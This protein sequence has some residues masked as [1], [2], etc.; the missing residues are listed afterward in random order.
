[1]MVKDETLLITLLF[2]D[3][4]FEQ[5]SSGDLHDAD[6]YVYTAYKAVFY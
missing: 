3:I 6:L 2:V 1:M 4:Y 5:V